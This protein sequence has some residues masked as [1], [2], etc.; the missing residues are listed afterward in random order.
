MAVLFVRRCHRCFIFL[1]RGLNLSLATAG[2]AQPFCGSTLRTPRTR[3]LGTATGGERIDSADSGFDRLAPAGS[4]GRSARQ[5]SLQCTE[6]ILAGNVSLAVAVEAAI[7][8][9]SQTRKK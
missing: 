1:A 3:W 6:V 5:N 8:R 4:Y 7:W 9:A 2:A